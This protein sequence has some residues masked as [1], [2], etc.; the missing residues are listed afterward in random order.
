MQLGLLVLGHYLTITA[1]SWLH[2]N[3]RLLSLKVLP[4]PFDHSPSSVAILTLRN[5]TLTPLAEIFISHAK[6]AA[7]LYQR[8]FHRN[9]TS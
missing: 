8:D 7:L 2:S 3:A 9:R 5:R 6:E 1:R 4:V